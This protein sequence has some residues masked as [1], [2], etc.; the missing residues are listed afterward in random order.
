MAP[1]VKQALKS[2][3][4]DINAIAVGV[5][6]TLS[7]FGIIIPPEAVAG[8]FAIGN[9]ILRFVTKKPLSEK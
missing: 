9:I 5:V 2:K 4:V 8:I 3:T 7:A 1:T 6:A